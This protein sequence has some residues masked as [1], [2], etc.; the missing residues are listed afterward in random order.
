MKFNLP[1]LIVRAQR[2]KCLMVLSKFSVLIIN[3]RKIM[4]GTGLSHTLLQVFASSDSLGRTSVPE[5][6]SPGFHVHTNHVRT[7]LDAGSDATKPG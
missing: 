6:R 1:L 7:L 4:M 5:P 2:C 3:L